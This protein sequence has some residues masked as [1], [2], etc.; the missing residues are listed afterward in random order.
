MQSDGIVNILSTFSLYTASLHY[1]KDDGM[2]VDRGNEA[3]VSA[4]EES[5]VCSLICF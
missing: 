3:E 5:F 4:V 1:K 2:R